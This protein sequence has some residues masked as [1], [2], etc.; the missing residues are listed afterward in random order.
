MPEL[1]VDP[2]YE[3]GSPEWLALRRTG[4]GGSDAAAA[5]GMSRWKTK[6]QLYFEKIG[7]SETPP[8]EAMRWGTI[9]EPVVRQEYCNQT[10]RI[11]VTPGQ[12]RHP[13]RDFA[14]MNADGIADTC[15]LY[16]GKTSRTAEEWGEPGSD[17]VPGDY[18]IQVQHGMAVLGLEVADIAVLIG[19]SDFR[20]YTVAADRE[21]QEMLLDQEEAFW[22]NHVLARVP[23]KPV[24]AEDVRRVWRVSSGKTTPA[25]PDIA[26]AV[27]ELANVKA[28]IKALDEYADTLAAA[29]QF[30]MQDAAA[31]VGDGGSVLATWKNINAAPK[32]DLQSFRELHPELYVKFLKDAG[33]QRRFLTKV[34]G[35]PCLPQ[36][37]PSPP[38]LPAA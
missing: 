5:V 26:K 34:E 11:V 19:G 27:Q 24:R 32:F 15:R 1:I 14:F 28:T 18:L 29:V 23:P 7:E 13:E 9:L 36:S 12:L 31:L 38:N 20:I 22:I 8:N 33:P 37:P 6:L 4:I 3:V 25:T 16:E 21:F 2:Q 30:N 17:E 35:V 10:G